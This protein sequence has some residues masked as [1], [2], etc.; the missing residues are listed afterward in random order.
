MKSKLLAHSARAE[1]GVPPQPYWEHIHRVTDLAGR[2]AIGAASFWR[3]ERAQFCG[4]IEAAALYHDCGKLCSENQAVLG[5]LKRE[6]LPVDHTDAGTALLLSKRRETA[7]MLVRSHHAGLPSVPE[8]RRRFTEVPPGIPFRNCEASQHTAELIREYEQ[9]YATEGIVVADGTSSITA[10]S[11]L[12]HRIALSCLVDADHGD[13]AR[14]YGAPPPAEP[15]ATRWRERLTMLDKYVAGLSE[16]GRSGPRQLNR[17][18]MYLACREA[19]I[20]PGLRTCEAP[21]GSG[22]TTAIMAHLL[23]VAEEKGLRHIF[24]VLPYTNIIQQ[25]VDTYRKAMTLIGEEPERVVAELHHLAEFEKPESRH[26]AALWD[27]PITVTTAVQ[28]FETLAARAPARL[29]KL[30]GLAGSAVFIDEEHNAIPTWLWPQT[31]LWIKEL[32]Q[33]WGCHFVLGSGSLARFWALPSI[34]DTPEEI[35]DLLP[36]E[37]GCA[38]REAECGRIALRHHEPVLDLQGLTKFCGRLQGPRLVILNTVQNAAVF[39]RELREQD[40]DVMHVSTALAPADRKP[41][42]DRIRR[43]LE[44]KEDTNWTLAAT[45]CVEAGLDFSFRSAIRESCSVSSAIQTGGRTNREAAWEGSEIWDVRLSDRLFNS[46]PAFVDSRRV[47]TEM[48]SEGKLE[49]LSPADAVTEALRR[50]ITLRFQDHS[51]LRRQEKRLN[52]EYV[53][54]HYQVI[55]SATR[56]V[57]VDPELVR[58]LDARERIGSREIMLGSVQMWPH[59][60]AILAVQKFDCFPELYKWTAPYDPGFLGYMK[61]MLPL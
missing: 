16:S 53:A 9:H 56:T 18:A 28:F 40:Q 31:W 11:G 27:A 39:A 57:V 35:P 33:D 59:K 58:R 42:I 21:V 50:E 30:H 2:N 4:E 26:M 25:S 10:W 24:V 37:L 55:G 60:I 36:P 6:K 12:T 19:A 46:H 32:V 48:F 45:S 23:Q 7:A 61:G 47:L 43:R 3:R 41:I 14:H 49:Q 22:K 44:D 34:V 13:T 29:R 54:K 15:L 8:E 17:T 52:F 5:G 1:Q 38:L 20:E 51:E